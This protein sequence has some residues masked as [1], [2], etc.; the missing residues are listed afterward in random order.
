MSHRMLT[1]QCFIKQ[2]TWALTHQVN[3]Q[4][5]I[6]LFFMITHNGYKSCRGTYSKYKMHCQLIILYNSLV[7]GPK[8]LNSCGGW[9][10]K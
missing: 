9:R 4:M 5:H 3:A 8:L 2:A 6:F 10:V 7:D 1:K